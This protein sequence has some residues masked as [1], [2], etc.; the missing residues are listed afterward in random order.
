M[1]AWLFILLIIGS[2]I[3]VFVVGIVA[4]KFYRKIRPFE[5]EASNGFSISVSH[6]VQRD[7]FF[8]IFFVGLLLTSPALY[9]VYSSM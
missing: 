1:E 2:I 7:G 9:F 4:V 3:G 6:N 5:E 8:K